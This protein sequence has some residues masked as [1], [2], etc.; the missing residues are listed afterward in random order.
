MFAVQN[1]DAR[2][3]KTEVFTAM[4]VSEIASLIDAKIYCGGGDDAPDIH[5]A[6]A[7]DMMSDVLAFV[8]SQAVLITGLV[9]PQVIRTAEMM[10]IPC[11]II[12][13]GKEP[14]PLMLELAEDSGITVMSTKLR[15]FAVCGILYNKGL[16]ADA[17]E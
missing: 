9:N 14:T 17:G 15:M 8:K 11:V 13:R 5:C 3:L 12:V 16:P 10:D 2:I 7:C 1:A 6:F 4:K